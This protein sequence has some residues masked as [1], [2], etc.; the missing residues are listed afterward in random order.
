MAILVLPNK[1]VN[2]DSPDSRPVTT[3]RFWGL[4]VGCPHSDGFTPASSFLL[5]VIVRI[6]PAGQVRGSSK[7]PGAKGLR[8]ALSRID[9]V[10]RPVCS[11]ADT[12][13]RNRCAL[14]HPAE[15]PPPLE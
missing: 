5:P 9:Q 4:R 15:M 2:K 8:P 10:P 13:R 11:C 7:P 12:A 3:L 14:A 6:I 1:R